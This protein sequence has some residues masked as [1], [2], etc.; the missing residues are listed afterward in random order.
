MSDD[1]FNLSDDESTNYSENDTNTELST[2]INSSI[3]ED[4]VEN[5]PKKRGR[6][7]KIKTEGEEQVKKKLKKRGRKP[8]SKNPLELLSKIPKKRGRKPKDKYGYGLSVTK[9]ITETILPNENENIILHLPINPNEILQPQYLSKSTEINNGLPTPYDENFNCNPHP[10]LQEQNIGKSMLKY[11]I[12]KDIEKKQNM[13]KEI[14]TENSDT[15][16]DER[17]KDDKV[18]LLFKYEDKPQ[19][20]FKASYKTKL[21]KIKSNENIIYHNKSLMTN[22]K[23]YK[24]IWPEKTDICCWWCCHP[25]D[26]VPFSLPLKKVNNHYIVKGCFCSP[27]CAAAWNFNDNS[28]DNVWDRYSLLNHIYQK[29]YDDNTVNIKLADPRETLTMF[30]GYQSIQ[31]FRKNNKIYNKTTKM[32]NPPMISVMPQVEESS[33]DIFQSNNTPIPLDYQRIEK[34]NNELRLKRTK[35]IAEKH[36]TLENCMNLKYS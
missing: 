34:A 12:Y 27:E 15:S 23:E 6:K 11:D 2:E 24:D 36:N 5:K 10:F 32:I 20:V 26:S 30:G 35:P 1:E 16:E 25:F 29:Y 21:F 18:E 4:V 7:P 14:T 9:V 17:D 19:K 31:E 28:D 8:K 22:F 13:K 33:N 3:I